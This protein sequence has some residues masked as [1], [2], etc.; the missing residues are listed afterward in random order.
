MEIWR[1]SDRTKSCLGGTAFFALLKIKS[2]LIDFMQ[3]RIIYFLLIAFALTGC[4]SS[5]TAMHKEVERQTE[6]LL[7]CANKYLGVS[8][9]GGGANPKGFDCSG[10]VQYVYGQ[11]GYALPRNTEQLA[12]FGSEVKRELKKGDLVFFRNRDKR[13]GK[14]GHVGI[15]TE[16]DKDGDFLFIHSSTSSGVRVDSGAQEYYK[17]RYVCARRIF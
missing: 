15:V 17:Q 16:V 6:M 5:N 2:S 8:Y 9:K 3:K 12:S 10:Y 14:I 1:V 4:R 13:R 7:T 11:V